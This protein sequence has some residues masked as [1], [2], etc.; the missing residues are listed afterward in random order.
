MDNLS[1]QVWKIWGY[2]FRSG[3]IGSIEVKLEDSE[4]SS[5]VSNLSSIEFEDTLRMISFFLF[6][7][8]NEITS[9]NKFEI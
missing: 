5:F 8:I 4:K 2:L 9:L 1:E 3:K 6:D 7:P